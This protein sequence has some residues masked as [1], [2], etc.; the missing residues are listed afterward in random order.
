[1][2]KFDETLEEINE[3]ILQRVG[4]RIKNV[5]RN[6]KHPY[7]KMFG[8]GEESL[9][10]QLNTRAGYKR[11]YMLGDVL[12]N[13]VKD[14][15]K[16]KVLT[17]DSDV[18]EVVDEIKNFLIYYGYFNMEGTESPTGK[19]FNAR[20]EELAKREQELEKR[21]RM[22]RFRQRRKSRNK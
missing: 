13:A 2:D 16:L 12:L 14:L 7:Q 21:E 22:E 6:I 4:Q 18:G 3:G 15:K 17:Q 5:G 8:T 9:A 20:E 19:H 1:M 10:A 11:Y